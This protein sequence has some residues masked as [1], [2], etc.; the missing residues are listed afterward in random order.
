MGVRD[1]LSTYNT[2]RKDATLTALDD[3]AVGRVL[4]E[5]APGNDVVGGSRRRATPRSHENGG[6][7]GRRLRPLAK[8]SRF[9]FP[10]RCA[11]ATAI[12]AWFIHS[13]QQD[14]GPTSRRHHEGRGSDCFRRQT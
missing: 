5:I 12:H 8:D 4:L 6:Q 7:E 14:S 1:F 9:S 3:S 10:T 11:R 2:N 13:I